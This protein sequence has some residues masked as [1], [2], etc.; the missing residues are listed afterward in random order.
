MQEPGLTE[1]IPLICTS[2][3]WGQY[4]VFSCP[5]LPQGSPQGVAA[6]SGHHLMAARW[7]V[8]F[9][10]PE[11]LQGGSHWKAAITEGCDIL[12]YWYGRKY[13]ISQLEIGK[14]EIKLYL[15]TKVHQSLTFFHL[16]E[17]LKI[18]ILI[19]TVCL[20]MICLPFILQAFSIIVVKGCVVFWM[21]IHSL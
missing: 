5:E 20:Y 14:K 17:F 2:A 18:V 9:F 4:P 11:F 1:I 3:T 16:Q 7:Q 19:L 21:H 8:F 6:G 13:P 10:F 12:V 15:S